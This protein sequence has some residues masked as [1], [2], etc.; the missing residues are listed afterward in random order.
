MFLAAGVHFFWQI[1]LGSSL[2]CHIHIFLQIFYVSC[3]LSSLNASVWSSSIVGVLSRMLCRYLN[4]VVRGFI[5]SRCCV[6]KVFL[7][8]NCILSLKL[9]WSRAYCMP[10]LPGELT[11]LVHSL[12]ELMPSSSVL[13][14]VGWLASSLLLMISFTVLAL[15][16]L[17]KCVTQPTASI[18]SC[19]PSNLW[20]MYCETVA[21]PIP[22]LIVTISSIR[23]H[24]LTGASFS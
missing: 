24:L 15:G 7:L 14:D 23:I 1:C 20:I 22:C 11:Y 5:C 12:A 2:G 9:L 10:C 21:S 17:R 19:H 16:C 18:T 8:Q 6:V 4:S 13:T 3:H